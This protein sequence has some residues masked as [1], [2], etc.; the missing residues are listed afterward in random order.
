M[1]S[2]ATSSVFDIHTKKPISVTKNKSGNVIQEKPRKELTK[3]E[4]KRLCKFALESR[5]PLRNWLAIQLTYTCA[6]R[7]V[8]LLALTWSHVDI[9]SSEI[10]IHRAKQHLDTKTGK[11]KKKSHNVTLSP[12]VKK[13]LAKLYNELEPSPCDPIIASEQQT[14]T[15]EYKAMTTSWF[16]QLLIR[17]NKKAKLGFTPAP[18]QLRHSGCT[19][20]AEAVKGNLLLIRNFAGHADTKT[21]EL[22]VTGAS[23]KEYKVFD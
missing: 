11:R 8:E 19:H 9:E 4:I 2:N 16:R 22:Y 10:T 6:L 23:F 13:A 17:L 21:S 20:F 5:N 1:P 3:T 14:I 18:H 7:S 15:G 12:K